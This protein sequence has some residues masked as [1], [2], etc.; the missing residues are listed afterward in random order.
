VWG[1]RTKVS[2]AAKNI[3]TDNFARYKVYLLPASA[4]SSSSFSITGTVTIAGTVTPIQNV[5]ISNGNANQ[6][7]ITD[8]NGKY[9]MAK[10]DKGKYTITFTHPNFKT[11]TETIDYNGGTLV[12]NISL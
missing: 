5:Q 12:L 6:N 10:L 7:T 2:K 8:S 9:G 4:E 11:H 1:F 3:Y